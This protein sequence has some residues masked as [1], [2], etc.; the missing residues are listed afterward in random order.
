MLSILN[1]FF[2]LDQRRIT[3]GLSILFL[4]TN[5]VFTVVSQQL[6]PS[7]YGYGFAAAMLLTSLVGLGLLSSKLDSLEYETFMMQNFA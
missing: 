4:L 3:L 6:G 1:I 5:A 2:Y 7:Y